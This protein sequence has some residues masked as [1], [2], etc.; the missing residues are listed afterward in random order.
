MSTEVLIHISAPSRVQD[1]TRYRK[2]A[3]GYLG[4]SASRRLDLSPE[5]NK[6]LDQPQ[7]GEPRITPPAANT[8]DIADDATTTDGSSS[9]SSQNAAEDDRNSPNLIGSTAEVTFNNRPFSR[10]D[11]TPA[12]SRSYLS[13][14]VANGNSMTPT[15]YVERTPIIDR[16]RTAPTQASPA[17]KVNQHQRSHSDSWQTPPSVIPDSQPSPNSLKRSLPLSASFPSSTQSASPLAK[18]QRLQ[19]GDRPPSSD[20]HSRP[21]SALQHEPTASQ[22]EHIGVQIDPPSFPWSDLTSQPPIAEIHPPQ[23]E[24]SM[25]VFTTHVTPA[26]ALI[27]ST[28]LIT[29]FYRPSHKVRSVGVHERGYWQLKI[30]KDWSVELRWKFWSFLEDLIGKGKAG[31]NVWCERYADRLQKTSAG[32]NLEGA[33]LDE[34]IDRTRVDRGQEQESSAENELVRVYCWG[35]LVPYIYFVLVMASDRRIKGIGATWVDAV[36]EEVVRMV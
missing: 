18:R 21:M 31:W 7:A 15:V 12:Q 10:L 25:A 27:A 20:S 22:Q 26:L 8:T 23:P 28:F 17:V 29:D 5:A 16:P 2:Q 14:L 11:L 30:G 35:E 36:G 19:P 4:F 33:I 32:E 9:S 34:R 6:S 3:E 13:V 24:T 1:D